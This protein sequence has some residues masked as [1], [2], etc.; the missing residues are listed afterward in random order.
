MVR[1][2]LNESEEA[3]AYVLNREMGYSM[4]RIGILMS[5]SQSTISNAIKRF[6]SKY[7]NANSEILKLKLLKDIEIARYQISV[8]INTRSNFDIVEENKMRLFLDEGDPRSKGSKLFLDENE[9]ENKTSLFLD[10][11]KQNKNNR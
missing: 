7:L 8:I 11:N 5:V 10:E 3:M 9:T 4:T 1:R 2:K 6:E